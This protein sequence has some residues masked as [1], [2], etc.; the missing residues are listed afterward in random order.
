MRI[1]LFLTFFY[2]HLYA[3]EREST[4]KVYYNLFS[5]LTRQEHVKVY[6]TDMELKRVFAGG[7]DRI[8]AVDDPSLSDIVVVTN[9]YAYEQLK[10]SLGKKTESEKQN[11]L[12]FTTDYHLLKK[13]RDIVGALYWKKG[14]SQ[15]LFL[16]PRLKSRHIILPNIYAPYIVDAL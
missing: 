9:E 5:A 4:L 14:R 8:M 13:Y 7:G 16:A 6:T 12:I 1:L 3:L 15:L 2:G 10:R 11:V